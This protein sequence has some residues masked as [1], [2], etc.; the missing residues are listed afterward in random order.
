MRQTK[1]VIEYEI[2]IDRDHRRADRCVAYEKTQISRHPAW[3]K[4]NTKRAFGTSPKA[5]IHLR[6]R[7]IYALFFLLYLIKAITSATAN[8]IP[9]TTH[10]VRN[11]IPKPT[12]DPIVG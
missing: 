4:R 9:L 7:L 8:N 6:L 5:F 12:L 3:L 10:V 1:E 2:P 11:A